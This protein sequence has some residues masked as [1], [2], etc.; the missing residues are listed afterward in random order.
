MGEGRELQNGSR[1]DP[2]S[3]KVDQP[4][5]RLSLAQNYS[6]SEIWSPA[7]RSDQPFHHNGTMHPTWPTSFP[8]LSAD[9][10]PVSWQL[11][12]VGSRRNNFPPG[13]STLPSCP[14]KNSGSNGKLLHPGS[15]RDNSGDPPLSAAV[16][17]PYSPR[18]SRPEAEFARRRIACGSFEMSYGG[19]SWMVA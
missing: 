16:T 7:R 15:R 8:A 19:W 18:Q 5:G 3:T 9:S 6:H 1:N 13:N 11:V 17:C 14:A 10:T 4:A 12:P 2:I